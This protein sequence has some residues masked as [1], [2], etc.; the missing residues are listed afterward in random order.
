ML[1]ESGL[2][3]SCLLTAAIVFDRSG[4]LFSLPAHF[5]FQYFEMQVLAFLWLSARRRWKPAALAAFVAATNFIYI[6]PLYFPGQA[7]KAAP[8]STLVRLLQMNVNSRNRQFEKMAALIQR[9]NADIVAIEEATP[10]LAQSLTASLPQYKYRQS[11]PRWDNF[12]L[13]LL[14]TEPLTNANTFG[15]HDGPLDNP[16]ET[17]TAYAEVEIRGARL[18]LIHT[19][20]LNAYTANSFRMKNEQIK[21]ISKISR[22]L[23][24]NIILVGDLNTTSWSYM[25]SDLV[26]GTGLRDARTG[27]GIQPTWS[28]FL[29]PPLRIPIDHVLVSPGVTVLKRTVGPDIG[30]DHLPVCTEVSLSAG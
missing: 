2:Y 9:T 21:L 10:A 3:L 7:A 6:A 27:F 28:T 14:S 16:L 20:L 25:F 19:H 17:P 26:S 12:G 8:N 5:R 15:F 1:V 4:W 24:G 18:T 22:R 23:K 11:I 29:L 30:S 13:L